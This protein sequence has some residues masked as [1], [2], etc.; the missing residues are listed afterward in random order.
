MRDVFATGWLEDID[1]G[2][3][4]KQV[5][6]PAVG[7]SHTCTDGGMVWI[8]FAVLEITYCVALGR[9]QLYVRLIKGGGSVHSYRPWTCATLCRFEYGISDSVLPFLESLSSR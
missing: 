3:R 6:Y 8:W 4:D 5:Q 9:L 2:D 7:V 1:V